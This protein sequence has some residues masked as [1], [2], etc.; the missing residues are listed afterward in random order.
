M[1]IKILWKPPDGEKIVSLCSFRD[2]VYVA[3][4]SNV[5]RLT[6]NELT[7]ERG[8]RRRSDREPKGRS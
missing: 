8:G 4:S 5:Y 1:N 3:T 7:D 2:R 6:E